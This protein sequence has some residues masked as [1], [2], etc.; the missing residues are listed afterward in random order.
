MLVR[1]IILTAKEREFVY[2]ARG[3]GASQ[4]YLLTRHCLPETRSVLATQA[5]LLI[6]QYI[7]AEVTLSFVGLGVS[8]P[9]ASWGNLLTPLRQVSVLSSTWW[10]AIPALVVM[11]TAWSFI[12]LEDAFAAA[13]K[14]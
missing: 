3:F 12:S 14:T 11:L 9:A 13:R 10:L 7:L 8:E 2:A 6:P 4:W 5:V 1:A